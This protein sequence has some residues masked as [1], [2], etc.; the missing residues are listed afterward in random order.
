[1]LADLTAI[2]PAIDAA[3]VST[4]T[5]TTAGGFSTVD[6]PSVPVPEPTPSPTDTDSVDSVEPEVT[7]DPAT[8]DTAVEPS[9]DAGWMCRRWRPRSTQHSRIRTQS[10]PSWCMRYR[11]CWWSRCWLRARPDLVHFVAVRSPDH[12]SE[13]DAGIGHVLRHPERIDGRAF[14]FS[15]AGGSAAHHQRRRRVTNDAISFPH[16]CPTAPLLSVRILRR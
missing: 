1:V 4:P 2:Q 7:P 3:A 5:A 15:L 10:R 14:R 6:Q 16:P 13:R 11:R 8:V 12:S 9:V